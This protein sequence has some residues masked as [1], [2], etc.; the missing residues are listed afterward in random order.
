LP[1]FS[2]IFRILPLPT[3]ENTITQKAKKRSNIFAANY[4]FLPL[5]R[6]A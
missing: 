4:R 6:K 5:S 2:S 3:H 1:L